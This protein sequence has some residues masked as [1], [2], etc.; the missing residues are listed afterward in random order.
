MSRFEKQ[1]ARTSVPIYLG[2]GRSGFGPRLSLSYD[3]GA[4]NGPF[5]FGW[6]LSLLS[7]MR[8]TDKGLPIYQ[9][10]DESGTFILSSAQELGPVLIRLDG[11]W[12]CDMIKRKLNG[13]DY[14]IQRY[15]PRVKGLFER[16]ER[17]TN[18]RIHE[19]H[20][21]SISRDNIITMYGKTAE[22]RIADPHN[23]QRVFSWLI[24]GSHD[25]NGDAILYEYK[26]ENSQ[27]IDF[28]LV[29]ER[30]LTDATRA[31]NRYLKRIKYGNKTPYKLGE[32]LTASNDWKFEV[33]FDYGEHYSVDNQSQPTTVFLKN[34][35]R[36]W[37]VRLDPFSSYRA[38]FEIRNDHLARR[39]L[40]LSFSRIE[41][42]SFVDYDCQ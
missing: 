42:L 4:G 40:F 1:S 6:N 36:H 3:S 15:R 19:I 23:P 39:V 7:F 18:L 26:A 25:D 28:S 29:R 34:D 32:D 41:V 20:W 31:T 5:G 12:Q 8:K 35:Q 11:Q 14:C 16:I 27:G 33:I 30:N 17:W 9:D 21:Q 10:D 2:L 37:K 13:V 22:S 38:G 24:C